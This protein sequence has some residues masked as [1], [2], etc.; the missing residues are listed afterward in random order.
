MR[1][2]HPSCHAISKDLLAL[3]I[4]PCIHT[5]FAEKMTTMDSYRIM[6]TLILQSQSLKAWP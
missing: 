2:C 4:A 5:L 6:Y 3:T 1:G